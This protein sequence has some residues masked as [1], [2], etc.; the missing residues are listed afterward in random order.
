MIRDRWV[1]RSWGWHKM[2]H[3]GLIHFL[4]TLSPNISEQF[5]TSPWYAGIQPQLHSWESKRQRR[6]SRS[7]R[8]S[9][10]FP[11]RCLA[12][13]AGFDKH[14]PSRIGTTDESEIM[15]QG[16]LSST[17]STLGLPDEY[18]LLQP[19]VSTLIKRCRADGCLQIWLLQPDKYWR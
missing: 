8:C 19:R 5:Y 13:S 12:I 14:V 6:L 1:G 11:K 4:V 15:P 2:I 3:H 16:Q 9:T 7:T 18:R 10:A 17:K